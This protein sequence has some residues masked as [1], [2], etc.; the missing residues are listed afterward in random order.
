M[1]CQGRQPEPRYADR[2]PDR[3]VERA[4]AYRLSARPARSEPAAPAWLFEPGV[5][6]RRI[7]GVVLSGGE[8]VAGARVSLRGESYALPGTAPPQVTTDAAGRFDFGVRPATGYAVMATADGFAA[9]GTRVDLRDPDV[10]PPP[11]ELVIELSPCERWSAGTVRDAR[12]GAVVD[13]V[14]AA[15]S[16][17]DAKSW[18]VPLVEAPIAAD[19]SF[20]L[21][22]P[23]LSP[24]MLWVSA[25]GYATVWLRGPMPEGGWD[26]VLLP[27]GVVEGVVLDP[28]G[29]P[30]AHA[31]VVLT[32][33]LAGNAFSAP[34]AQTVLSGEDGRF[35]FAGVAPGLYD[36]GADH[37]Q[38]GTNWP[39][40]TVTVSPGQTSEG[41]IVQMRPCR[42]VAGV[43]VAGGEPVVGARVSP[44]NVY[45]QADGSFVIGC[46]T[47]EAFDIEVDGFEVDAPTIAAGE[48]DIDDLLVAVRP[49][50]TVEQKR[51]REPPRD[52][53]PS[54]AQLSIA[55]RVRYGD[56]SP[57]PFAGVRAA[58]QGSHAVADERGRFVLAD[59]VEGR[60]DL[61]AQ[62]TDGSV[63]KVP[64]AAAGDQDVEIVVSRV[65]ALRVGIE[66][67]RG[68]C[69][70]RAWADTTLF[71]G[72]AAAG[73]DAVSFD[74]VPPGD[75]QVRVRCGDEGGQGSASVAPGRSAAVAVA[76]G[77]GATVQGRAV[78]SGSGEPVAG[79]VCGANGSFARSG[80]DGSFELTQVISGALVVDCSSDFDFASFW[81]GSAMLEVGS[82][83]TA[84]VEVVVERLAG[85]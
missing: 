68:R 21:C 31:R 64:G 19:G 44:G 1:R 60:H 78:A 23:D 16:K 58:G 56:G 14:V 2:D 70:V 30:L 51:E 81:S 57:A 63:G 45:T 7:A 54:V 22:P 62:A 35:R 76:V 25:P 10:Q 69:T 15:A 75:Y 71:Q 8:P 84:T 33:S 9:A 74:A 65:G 13:G 83:D 6:G 73:M 26:V 85:D 27:E 49:R 66:G 24:A 53:G 77:P 82:G 39:Q 34:P 59:L 37:G 52:A 42:A 18:F 72:L 36:V 20:A 46:T 11:D 38:H 43:V 4:S 28:G 47:F 67:A 80:K 5:S 41:V 55:G 17:T 40:P 50:A 3:R 32:W 12:G 48:D 29:E 61:L 79:L